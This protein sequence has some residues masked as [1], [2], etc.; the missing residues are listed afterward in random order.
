MPY[1]NGHPLLYQCSFTY[2]L[3]G[4]YKGKAY[5]SSRG[6][7]FYFMYIP[8]SRE[9]YVYGHGYGDDLDFVFSKQ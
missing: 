1:G 4:P 9:M 3:E 6:T 2:I 5:I 7:T 8:E